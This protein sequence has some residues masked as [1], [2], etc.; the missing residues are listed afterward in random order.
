MDMQGQEA[1]G[2]TRGELSAELTAARDAVTACVSASLDA[3][4]AIT[5]LPA[6]VADTPQRDR[7][8]SGDTPHPPQLDAGVGYAASGEVLSGEG[9]EE[10]GGVGEVG[11]ETEGGSALAT[12]EPEAVR[13]A[14]RWNSW[15][16]I[17]RSIG[18]REGADA[19]GPVL[20][21]L[22]AVLRYWQG[23]AAV[24]VAGLADAQVAIAAAGTARPSTAQLEQT[25]HA[26]QQ[27]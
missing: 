10:V 15:I 3:A 12:A 23:V 2:A 13:R 18:S 1:A 9:P 27:V 16:E 5:A 26:K 8:S 11:M 17:C 4:T 22:Q 6:A 24:T 19:P 7:L 20:R 25:M 14:A 21:E